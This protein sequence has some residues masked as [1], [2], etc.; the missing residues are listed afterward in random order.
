MRPSLCMCLCLSQTTFRQKWE[1]RK[2]IE[3][4]N[5]CY[6]KQKAV[7][8]SLASKHDAE[9]DQAR[10]LGAHTVTICKTK[11][12]IFMTWVTGYLWLRTQQFLHGKRLKR[13]C[14]PLETGFI[15]GS[16]SS[17]LI[18]L[19]KIHYTMSTVYCKLQLQYVCTGW[20]RKIIWDEMSHQKSLVTDFSHWH[21]WYL[22]FT[23]WRPGVGDSVPH[24]WSGCLTHL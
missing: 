11:Q 22:V 19:W 6:R 3:D 5:W 23:Q 18:K 24:V 9:G 1:E 17:I 8:S 20:I 4:L 21:W 16:K 7:C 12:K 2:K 15:F 14:S 10:S 13:A